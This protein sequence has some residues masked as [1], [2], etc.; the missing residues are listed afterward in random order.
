MGAVKY[1]PASEL[2]KTVTGSDEAHLD[3]CR[4]DWIQYAQCLWHRGTIFNDDFD[5]GD[6]SRLESLRRL[7]FEAARYR[8]S[9]AFFGALALR[10]EVRL[11]DQEPLPGYH[12]VGGDAVAEW[13][14]H[15]RAFPDIRLATAWRE[16]TGAVG[17]LKAMTQLDPGE[18][19]IESG[20]RV[21]GKARPGRVL[22]REKSPERLLL[23]AEA[24]DPTW[25]FVLRGFSSYRTV[26]LDGKP[27]ED[28]PAQ[29]A[30]SAIRM[31]AGRHTIDWREQLPG[32]S[33]SRWGP[34]LFL[35]GFVG[36]LARAPRHG[37]GS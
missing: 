27:V 4:R 1:S 22:I 6:F 31:P 14:E 36:V 35:L 3:L 33:V 37:P 11:R 19:A 2:G 8:D 24:P 28:V 17:A 26:L 23:V 16:E 29:L 15:E 5:E 20:A 32:W 12:R 25:L 18:I 34:V 13:D 10:W 9:Q 21:R 30:F 7:S